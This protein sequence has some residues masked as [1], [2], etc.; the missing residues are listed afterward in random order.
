MAPRKVIAARLA[1]RVRALNLQAHIEIIGPLSIESFAPRAQALKRTR[2][3]WLLVQSDHSGCRI[4]PWFRARGTPCWQCLFQWLALRPVPPVEPKGEIIPAILEQIQSAVHN[5]RQFHHR[6]CHIDTQGAIS[7]HP[8]RS[9]PQCPNCGDPARV[10]PEGF[11]RITPQPGTPSVDPSVFISQQTSVVS[12]LRDYPAKNFYAAEARFVAPYDPRVPE[13]RRFTEGL[14]FGGGATLEEARLSATAEALERY[15]TVAQGTE[16][17]VTASYE[18]LGDQAIWPPRLFQFSDR[19]YAQRDRWHRGRWRFP[20]IPI[21]YESN[22]RIDWAVGWS[23]TAQCPRL[24]PL[25]YCYF[26]STPE[27]QPLFAAAD[28]IG[29]AAGPSLEQAILRALLE[30]IERDAIAVW[31]ANR[32]ARPSIPAH[33]YE[34]DPAVQGALTALEALNR[35]LTVLDLS[36]DLGVTVLG[37]VSWNAKRRRPE[38]GFGADPSPRHALRKA[39]RELAQTAIGNAAPVTIQPPRGSMEWV[40][41]QW[42]RSATPETE[43]HL[44]PHGSRPL[45]QTENPGTLPALLRTFHSRNFEVIAVDLTRP[46]IGLP[47]VRVV[48][49]DLR[50]PAMRLAEGRLYKLPVDLGWQRRQLLEEE[51]NPVPYPL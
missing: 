38:L 51:I 44:L 28:S 3:R 39:I 46:E 34:S 1:S 16:P 32:I 47:V 19:Q 26:A 40:F 20:F 43:P 35:R 12:F 41:L 4:G 5:P 9:R 48:C 29:C 50:H 6:L 27:G 49:P 36:T 23:L 30:C 25:S 24:L 17:R 37:A 7:W 13:P 8:V 42:R 22:Y 31:W 45:N 2:R 15:C 11:P 21:R 18:Q 33:E 10:L 14:A